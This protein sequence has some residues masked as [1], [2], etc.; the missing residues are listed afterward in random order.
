M[1]IEQIYRAAKSRRVRDVMSAPVVT[2]AED[3]SI[4]TVLARMFPHRI[5][6]LPVVRGRR[7]VGMVSSRDLLQLVFAD[8]NH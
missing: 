5:R 7:P 2:V 4:E 1:Q 8:A 3:D 6:Y